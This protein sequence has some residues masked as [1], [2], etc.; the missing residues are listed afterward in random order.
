MN[1]YIIGDEDA[2]LGFAMI[3]VDGTA[4]SKP[5]EA[6]AVFSK[7]VSDNSIGIIIITHSAA[8][9]MRE[10]VSRY[11]FTHRFPLIVEISDRKHRKE[12]GKPLRELVNEAIGIKL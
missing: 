3:G 2:V 8:S 4:V 11:V 7:A 1:Y 5:E 9:M 6:E 10:K 12:S